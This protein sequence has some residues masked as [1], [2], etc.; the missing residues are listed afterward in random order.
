MKGKKAESVITKAELAKQLTDRG[1]ELASSLEHSPIEIASIAYK[2]SRDKEL[3]VELGCGSLDE[4]GKKYFGKRW[5]NVQAQMRIYERLVL[6]AELPEED[7][8][9][10]GR[11]KAYEFSR[12]PES[13]IRK[14]DWIQAAKEL[15]T[16]T[17]KR[18]VKDFLENRDDHKEAYCTIAFKAP[19]SFREETYKRVLKAGL[20]HEETDEPHVVVEAAFA[21]YE[22]EIQGAEPPVELE[23]TEIEA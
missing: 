13:E 2:M 17:F 9:A 18:K 7:I 15:D 19:K 12:L 6:N 10:M 20:I 16:S 3:L 11:V 4:W 22:Q 8:V 21:T 5:K 1:V 23:E 14:P